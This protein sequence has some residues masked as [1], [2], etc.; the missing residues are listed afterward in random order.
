MWGGDD[1][2]QHEWGSEQLVTTRSG[3]HNGDSKR[4]APTIT[5]A[6]QGAFCQRCSAW[7]GL[8]GLEPTI[9]LY[10]EHVVECFREVRR[11]LRDDGVCFVNAGDS[12]GRSSPSG[13]QGQSGQR[14][15]R[16]FTA[17]GCPATGAPKQLIGQPWRIAFALQAD[18][19]WLRSALPWV[20]RSAMPEADPDRPSSALEHVFMFT[21]SARCYWD[22][23]AVRVKAAGATIQR[24]K[25]SRILAEDG[26]QAVR[27]DHETQVDPSGRNF[28]N[29]DLYFESLKPPYGMIFVGDEPVGLD[30]TPEGLKEKHFAS[31]PR[32]LIRPLIC[33]STSEKGCCP[34]CGA[35]WMRVIE[36]DR[37][38]TRPARDNK[39]DNTGMA[40]RDHERHVTDVK[41]LG[42]KPGCGCVGV[43]GRDSPAA[44]G[45]IEKRP[46]AACTVL[47]PFVGSGQAGIVATQQGRKFIGIDASETYCEMARRRIANPEP[48][49]EIQD[50]EGQMQ[51]FEEIANGR[52][53]RA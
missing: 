42:W 10:V 7:R 21:K 19:W 43:I 9:D 23:E 50:V 36:R 37:R 18:G 38:T 40:N 1:K 52:S 39:Q 31:F 49:P 48:E 29:T 12:Y 20:K 30:V 26:P 17:E 32:K 28:R 35:P 6:S 44:M 14:A 11:V 53:G 27:H 15:D 34:E 45:E 51:M 13:P 24:D 5:G 16:R 4:M 22:R 8:L 25:Y 46:L 33:V 2:C 47:D 3:V 41:T